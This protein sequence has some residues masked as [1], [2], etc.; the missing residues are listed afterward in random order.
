[1]KDLELERATHSA[2]PC[3]VERKN[4]GNARSDESARENRRGQGQTQAKHEE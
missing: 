3:A 1:M 4:E 2:P